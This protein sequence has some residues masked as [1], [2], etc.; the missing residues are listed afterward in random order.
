MPAIAKSEI[1]GAAILEHPCGKVSV[2]QMGLIHAGKFDEANKLSTTQMQ[3]QWKAMPAK[4]RQMMSGMAK[5]MSQT[6]EQ[7][8]NDVK[9]N[10]LLVVDGKQAVLTVKST[11]RDAN[12][13]STSTT[14]QNFQVDGNQCMVS[15]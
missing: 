15:R 1:K 9:A 11:K 14:T 6:P 7:F 8:S 10:G 13:S 2:K 4:D 3:E 5:E 12:G